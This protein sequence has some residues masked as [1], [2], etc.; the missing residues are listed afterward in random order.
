MMLTIASSMPQ[1]GVRQQQHNQQQHS[2]QQQQRPLPQQVLTP[3]RRLLLAS[4]GAAVLG[5]AVRPR[6][7]AATGIE[8]FDAPTFQAP[9]ALLDFTEARSRQNRQVLA[10][11]EDSFQSSDLLKTLR[12]R[13]EASRDA[14]KAELTDRYCRRQAEMGVGDCGGL[15]WVGDRRAPGMRAGQSAGV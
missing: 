11:A 10:D 4:V 13:T 5:G 8:S 15:R 2:Q 7:A 6:L 14:N 3:G 1:Q 9:Q 12:D